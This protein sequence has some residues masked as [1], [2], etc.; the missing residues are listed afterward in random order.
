MYNHVAYSTSMCLTREYVVDAFEVARTAPCDTVVCVRNS[1]LHVLKKVFMMASLLSV[2]KDSS[3]LPLS[4]SS[5]R[6]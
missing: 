1:V 5:S 4:L 3:S 2:A 6:P